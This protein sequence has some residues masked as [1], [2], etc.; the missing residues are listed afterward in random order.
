MR[1]RC[2]TAHKFSLVL[3]QVN[4]VIGSV[5]EC[6]F[7]LRWTPRTP[8]QSRVLLAGLDREHSV[9]APRKG[10]G[11]GRTIELVE[12]DKR[13]RKDEGRRNRNRREPGEAFGKFAT[14]TADHLAL[15]QY[16]WPFG[17]HVMSTSP[18]SP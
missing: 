6:G 10:R 7:L 1:S 17:Q 13:A 9:V 16:N 3:K 8:R 12:L 2:R 15:V 4:W 5:V 11:A 14:A 18:D